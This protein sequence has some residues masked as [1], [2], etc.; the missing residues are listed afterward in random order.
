MEKTPW[1]KQKKTYV[2][3][4]VIIAAIGGFATGTDAGAV[5]IQAIV[6]GLLQLF[7]LL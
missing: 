7:G 3:L 5:A 4:G 1:F 2:G 6:N